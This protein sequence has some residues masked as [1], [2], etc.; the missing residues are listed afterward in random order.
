M[1]VYKIP[2]ISQEFWDSRNSE[3]KVRARNQGLIPTTLG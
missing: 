3:F 2:K 1:V